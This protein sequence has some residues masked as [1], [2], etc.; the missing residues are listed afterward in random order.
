MYVY[1]FEEGSSKLR[2]LLGGKGADLAEMTGLGLPIPPGITVTTAACN[3]YSSH[4]SKFPD[5]L[6]DEIRLKMKT[7]ESKTRRIFGDATNPLLVSVR[8][9]APISMPGMMDTVLNLG[10]ND[11]TVIGLIQQTNNER[12]AYDAYRRFVQ[13]FGK[14]VL[15]VRGDAFESIIRERKEKL[16]VKSD[17]ELD[18]KTLASLVQEF[19]SLI[20]KETGQDFPEDPATQLQLA[21][22]AVFRSWNGHRALVYREANKIPET[23]GTAVNIQTM[24]FG[25]MG[26]DSGTGVCFTRNPSTGEPRLFGEFL[27]NAQGEDVVAGIRTPKPIAQ[28]KDEMPLVYSQLLDVCKM[29]EQHFKDMQDIEFTVEKGKLFILQTR[30]GKRT[31]SAAIRIVVDMVKEGFL[32]KEQALLRVLPAHLEQLVHKQIDPSFNAKPIATGLPAS[33][34]A[35]TGRVIFDTDEAHSLGSTGEAVILVREE[36]TPEDIHGMIA[37]KGVLTSRGGMTCISGQTRVLTDRGLLS[38][39]SAYDLL[40][41]GANLQILSF[42]TKR[43]SPL[44]RRVIAAGRRPAKTVAISISQTGRSTQGTVRLTPDHKMLVIQNRE[45]VKKRI[46]SVLSDCDFISILDRIPRCAHKTMSGK[47]AYVVGALLSDGYVHLTPTKGFVTFIQKP[48][49]EKADFIS[50]VEESFRDEFGAEFTY[51]RQ[52][53]SVA[54]L[55]QREI[56]GSVEDRISFRRNP[57]LRLTLM[58]K[59]LARW[60]LNAQEEALLRFLAGYIDGDGTYVASSSPV[61]IQITV[62]EKKR[63]ILEGLALA[64]LRLGIVPQVTR[65]RDALGLIIAERVNDI[66]AFTK[67]VRGHSPQRYYDSKCYSMRALFQDV[68]DQVDFKGRIRQAVARN[69]MFGAEKIRRDLVRQCPGDVGREVLALLNSPIR[70]FR[71]RCVGGAL[72]EVVY[73]FEVDASTELDKNFIIFSTGMTPVIVSNSHA[74]VVARGMG[75]PAVV[76]CEQI[77]IDLSTNTMSTRKVM[78]QK[79][80]VITIDGTTGNVLLG[81]V[82]TIDPKLGAEA[83]QLLGWADEARR[84]GVRANAD[85]PEGAK[86]AREFGAGGIGLCR[87]ERMFNAQDRLPIVQEMILSVTDEERGQALEKLRP[88][89]KEDFKEI[90]RNMHDLPVTIRLL[91]LPLHEFLPR[92]DELTAEVASLKATGS[93][94]DLL[95]SKERMLRKVITLAEHNPML[96]HRGCRLAISHPEIYEMQTRAIFEAATE[97]Q[98]EGVR[99]RVEIMLPLVGEANEI[100]FLREKI[101]SVAAKVMEKMGLRIEFKVGTM[102]EVPRAAL[103]ADEIARY[104]DFFSFGTNDLT[105]ATFAFSRDDAEAKFFKDYFDKKILNSNPFEVLDRRGVGKLMRLAVEAGKKSNPRLKVGICGEHGGEPSSVEFC[106]ELGLDYVSCSPYRVPVARLV[107]AQAVAREKMAPTTENT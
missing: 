101:T 12:F 36:T 54:F 83:K 39:E 37:A 16:G 86:V 41:N 55:G 31:A 78:V 76:G 34:G 50:A 6:E 58:R 17:I 10:L 27:I 87:T 18:T 102:I 92:Y 14:V 82:P 66:L 88:L 45:F 7:L 21:V 24:V 42:D 107:A 35:A 62:A 38:A 5:G 48:T 77:K 2:S 33:P 63:D 105:Q 43:L 44:W 99:V 85:T 60:V 4:G 95:E 13:M 61:R 84:L 97:L 30:S 79:N 75:K 80:D 71:A 65:N 25:N 69:I 57:A 26:P 29:L 91:D 81:V 49:R 94:A 106:H 9:G 96:G 28:L 40:Q 72:S 32:S 46:D 68:V 23:L 53:Q 74:A 59:H 15:G 64:C 89:Q 93:S 90:F 51:I 103:T 1:L 8:S 100:R 47:L 11:K 22:G 67:R 3:Y 73:N 70:S 52:R 104:A 20:R 19:K 98:N 56:R